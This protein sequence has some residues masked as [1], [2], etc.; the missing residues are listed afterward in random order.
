MLHHN[1]VLHAAPHAN[2]TCML[3]FTTFAAGLQTTRR[4]PALAQLL[5][6]RAA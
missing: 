2:D 1:S 5:P 4:W 6:L 3:T